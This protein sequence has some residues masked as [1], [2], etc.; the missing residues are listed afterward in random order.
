MPAIGYLGSQSPDSYAP[1]VAAFQD[2]LNY[3][4]Y[5]QGRNVAI[6]YRWA[7]GDDDQCSASG[8]RMRGLL[9]TSHGVALAAT[10][11]A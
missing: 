10:H 1:Y 6:E 8:A 11:E 7:N 2:G 4:G 5:I 3:A 9:R